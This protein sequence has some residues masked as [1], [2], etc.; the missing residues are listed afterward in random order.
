MLSVLEAASREDAGMFVVICL[1][2]SPKL[3][4][5]KT[6]VRSKSDSPPSLTR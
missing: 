3:L 1:F 2:A 5:Y 6:I 4:P